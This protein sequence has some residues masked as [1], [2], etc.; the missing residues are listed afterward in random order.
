LQTG[1]AHNWVQTTREM[2]SGDRFFPGVAPAGPLP[3]MTIMSS[4]EA[5]A[6]SVRTMHYLSIASATRSIFIANPYFVPDVTAIAQLVE[7][8]RRGVDVRIM[9]AGI[10]NDNWVA[11]QNAT[12]LIGPLLEAGIEVLE[13]NRTMPHQKTTVVDER[14]GTVGTTNADSRSPDLPERRRRLRSHHARDLEATRT[15][16]A[17]EG[18]GGVLSRRTGVRRAA[19]PGCGRTTA[20]A[21]SGCPRSLA[22]PRS[23]RGMLAVAP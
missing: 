18:S 17:D 5:G 7:A 3:A 6:S 12:R 19:A 9:L 14:W 23:G 4:P 20:G 15:P 11:R 10:H 16:P 1:F 22:T 13:F 2:I 8:Q 21:V